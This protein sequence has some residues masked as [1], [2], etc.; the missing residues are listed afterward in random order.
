[1]VPVSDYV[2]SSEVFVFDADTTRQCINISILL[3][4]VIEPVEEFLGDLSVPA[5]FPTT[6]VTVAPAATTIAI[7]SSEGIGV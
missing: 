3:D 4:G 2:T 5:V 1:M 6:F 7:T